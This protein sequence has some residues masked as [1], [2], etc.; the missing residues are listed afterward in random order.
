MTSD[1]KKRYRMFIGIHAKTSRCTNCQSDKGCHM[2]KKHAIILAITSFCLGAKSQSAHAFFLDGEGHYGLKGITRTKPSFDKADR[3]HQAIEQSFRL[4]TEIRSSDK[5]SMF[6]EMRLFDNERAAYMGDKTRLVNC[7]KKAD[8][9]GSNLGNADDCSGKHADVLEPRYQAYTPQIT[10]AYVR[11]ATDYCLITAGRRDRQWGLGMYMDAGRKPFDTDWT[12]YDGVTCDINMQ[13][14]Q[15]LGFSFGYDKI[16]ETGSTVFLT[17]TGDYVGPGENRDDLDQIFLTLVYNDKNDG[18]KSSQ[19]FSQEIGIY[20]ANLL[21]GAAN[22]T[23]IKIADLFIK[24]GFGD[25]IIEQEVLF[26]LGKTADPNVARLGGLPSREPTG[27]E[28]GVVKNDVQ[29]IAAAGQLEYFLSRSGSYQGPSQF[30]RGN[31]KSHSL[32]AAYAYAPGDADGYYPVYPTDPG[33]ASKRDTKATAVAFHRNFKPALLLFNAPPESDQNR[34]DGVFDPYRLINVSVFSLGYRYK[35][36][37]NGNLEFKLITASLNEGITAEAKEAYAASEIKPVG[38]KGKD[39]GW[40]I[41]VSYNKF[42]GDSLEFGAAAAV[43][44]PG[45]AM[46]RRDNEKAVNSYLLQAHSTFHF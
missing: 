2:Q 10:K 20:F 9:E 41:D 27:G 13:N 8:E 4:N 16:T 12:V 26:R 25:L 45:E 37:E 14:N 38:Y 35:S 40:E 42:F 17:D 11:Y 32:F 44:L 43:A 30:N 24:L 22:D 28:D 19:D 34:I 33:E 21:G 29:S 5:A 6:L 39:L 23:D 7:S 18:Q 1:I 46:K 15:S 3:D 31:A 36:L